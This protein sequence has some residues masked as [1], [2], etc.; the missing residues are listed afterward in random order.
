MIETTIRRLTASTESAIGI[1]QDLLCGDNMRWWG[2]VGQG[3]GLQLQIRGQLVPPLLQSRLLGSQAL[4][5]FGFRILH[6]WVVHVNQDLVE[7]D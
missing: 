3:H 5:H 1:S 2:Q 7:D 6:E 4:L